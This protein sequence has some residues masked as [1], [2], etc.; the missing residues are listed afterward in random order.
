VVGLNVGDTVGEQVI[1][2]LQDV[3]QDNRDTSRYR[4]FGLQQ[5]SSLLSHFAV[6]KSGVSDGESVGFTV[7]DVDGKGEGETVGDCVG[8]GEGDNVGEYVGI[9]VTGAVEG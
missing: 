1:N 8:C 7:G 9:G 6:S 3:G 2:V 5:S 4:K